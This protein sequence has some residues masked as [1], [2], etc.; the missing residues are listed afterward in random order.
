MIEILKKLN[1]ILSPKNK[2]RSLKYLI[3]NFFNFI[4][5]FLSIS[6]ILFF[7]NFFLT[8]NNNIQ[9]FRFSGINA[10]LFFF[11]YFFNFFF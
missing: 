6:A 2:K 3:I 8:E 5:E 7:L 4:L 11:N 9:E 10:N 1:F